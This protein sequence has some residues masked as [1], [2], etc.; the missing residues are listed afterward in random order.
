MGTNYYA[1]KMVDE[2]TKTEIKNAV[3]VDD[4]GRVN[5]MIPQRIHI[6]KSAGGW[7]FLFNHNMWNHFEP[8]KTSLMLF[9]SGCK[10][11]D[12]YDRS[13]SHVDFWAMIKSKSNAKPE[14]EYGNMFDGLCFSNYTEF[15]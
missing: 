5:A 1:I 10:I 12:E 4:W 7:Q 9:L 2:E 15:S 8:T 14:L 13:V 3:D 11:Y 6:G